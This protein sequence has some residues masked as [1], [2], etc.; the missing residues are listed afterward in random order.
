[1]VMVI[2]LY[3]TRYGAYNEGPK[4]DLYIMLVTYY[5]NEVSVVN[6]KRRSCKI[7]ILLSIM[8]EIFVQ[9]C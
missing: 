6:G 3:V 2:F 8:S 9:M 5:F 7:S 1:M 4:P